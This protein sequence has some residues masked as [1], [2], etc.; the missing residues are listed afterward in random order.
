[1]NN[2]KILI[3][4][5]LGCFVSACPAILAAQQDQISVADAARKAQAARKSAPPPKMVVDNDSLGTLKGTINVV[6]ETPSAGPAQGEKSETKGQAK[7]EGYWRQKFADANKKLA[8]DSKEL[9]IT[10]RE[11]NLNQQQYY[12]DPMATLKQEYSRQDLNNEK[13][14]I[15]DLTARVAQDKA[16]IANLEDEL[17]QAGGDPGWASPPSSS[18]SGTGSSQPAPASSTPPATSTQPSAG[19]PAPASSPQ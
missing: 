10:Q 3:V 18:E 19:A 16:D 7:D 5:L 9:D 1:M 15:D 14:K 13:A 17:R 2:S 6:G 11:R 12:A 8:D 4:L